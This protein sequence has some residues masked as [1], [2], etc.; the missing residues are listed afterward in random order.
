MIRALYRNIKN[1]IYTANRKEIKLGFNVAINNSLLSG[2]NCINNNTVFVNS[3]LGRGSYIGP[4]CFLSSVEVG[5]YCSIGSR[6]RI[7]NS[8]HP[9]SIFVS[10][11]PAFYS[12][13]KQ[14]GFTYVKESYYEEQK[15]LGNDKKLSVSIGNDVWIG[16]D[17][18]I[19]GGIRIGDG[20][21]VGAGAIVSKDITPYTIV[22]GVPAKVIK[23]R[24]SEKEI[25]FLL[26]FRWWE[27]DEHWISENIQLFCNI[28]QFIN[29]A[30]K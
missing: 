29:L 22:G 23:K 24:F 20:A 9:A 26:A 16:D 27:K 14:A 6:V 17:V 10:T 25:E 15:F 4:D 18:M 28:N 5:L 30:E 21:I 19:M 8:N 7:V 11:H 2:K 12:L 1:V 13:R 3:Y